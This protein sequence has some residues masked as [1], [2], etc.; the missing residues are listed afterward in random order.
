[1]VVPAWLLST[2]RLR[3]AATAHPLSAS[4]TSCDRLAHRRQ[5][6]QPTTYVAATGHVTC[7]PS[8]TARS[9]RPHSPACGWGT[10]AA[11]C[12]CAPDHLHP[13]IEA[14][15]ELATCRQQRHHHTYSASGST[16][17]DWSGDG[18]TRWWWPQRRR[19]RGKRWAATHTW[20]CDDVPLMVVPL[21]CERLARHGPSDG[22]DEGRG[23]LPH[24]PA[25]AMTCR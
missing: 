22:E 2:A 12:E 6:R 20:L 23:G 17:R 16:T 10:V 14:Y 3:P 1:M 4:T 11:G 15:E 5:R 21:S 24:T 19:G 8:A 7:P 18:S 9:R 25:C 13:Q